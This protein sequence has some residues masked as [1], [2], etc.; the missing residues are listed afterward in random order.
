LTS[1][2]SY[3]REIHLRYNQRDISFEFASLD[4]RKPDENHYAYRL[5]GYQ[6]NWIQTGANNRIASY[7][8]L[9][10]GEYVFHVRA[11]NND[12]L[13][14][15]V[16]KSIVVVINP[17]WYK[18]IWA[19]AVYTV[20]FLLLLRGYIG[21][22]TWKLRKEKNIL[23]KKVAERTQLIAEQKEELLQQKDQLQCTL[24]QLHR[25]QE[26]LIESKKMAALGGLVAGVAHEINTP[27]GI[28]V[29]AISALMDDVQRM[30]E[31]FRKNEISRGDFKEFLQS[32]HEA[33]Q[34]IH[35]NLERTAQLVQSFK[36]VSVDQ[37]TEQKRS[38]RLKAYL[39]DIIASLR[40]KLKD[41][42][43]EFKIDC[44][45][46]LELESYPGVYAQVFTNLILNS[47]LHGFDK[48][49]TGL[50]KISAVMNQDRLEILY[51][52]NGTG[53]SPKDLPHIFEPFYTSDQRRGLG[54]G[55]HIVYN[56][57]TQ[58]LKGTIS[59]ESETGKGVL[60]RISLPDVKIP[61]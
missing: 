12:G 46:T 53:I 10:P 26:Q 39:I 18:T 54:L 42:P 8:N 59:C 25:T 16:G 45:D 34:L 6:E 24:E 5:E 49:S 3:S 14:N 55:L 40:P 57:I 23:E 44:D 22:R 4:Y 35:K 21:W 61:G 1:A 47:R 38:F 13:W 52:D 27:V 36:L 51:S 37:V 2:I 9:D 60:F 28:G 31:Q 29:T 20:L 17:P 48:C 15:E 33:G 56:L 32:A 50:I 19:Y 7:T 43:I 30:D 11:S 41:R 58:K